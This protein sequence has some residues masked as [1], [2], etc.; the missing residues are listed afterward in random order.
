MIPE[1]NMKAIVDELDMEACDV[2]M[3]YV[4]R[5]MSKST[6]CSSMLKLHSLIYE[7]AGQGCVMR[8]L[9]D[10]KTV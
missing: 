10:R 1:S 2:L 7:K 6:N 5:F 3:K 8:V 9:T 4:Y